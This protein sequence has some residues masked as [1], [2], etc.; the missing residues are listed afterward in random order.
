MCGDDDD[1]NDYIVHIW[2]DRINANH[3]CVIIFVC[4]E[5]IHV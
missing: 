2:S 5:G 4:G 3:T 1:I